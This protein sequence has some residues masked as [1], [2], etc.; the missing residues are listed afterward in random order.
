MNTQE[1]RLNFSNHKIFQQISDQL[2]LKSKLN[3]KILNGS[4]KSF[5]ISN[6]WEKINSKILIITDS[7]KE[8][9]N[10]YNDLDVFLGAENVSILI[11]PQK[12]VRF[13]V[14][15]LDKHLIWLIDGIST[16]SA[17]QN[18]IAIAT[19]DIFDVVIPNKDDINKN[20][21]KISKSE[22]V[23]FEEFKKNLAFNGFDKK[24]FVAI[25]GDM[26]V[27]GGIIDIFPIAWENP[28]RIEFWGNEVESIR[29][30]DVLSQRSIREY[31]EVE[32]IANMFQH[33]QDKNYST[34]LNY[35]NSDS[36]LIF[37]SP[38]MISINYPDYK[39]PDGFKIININKIGESDITLKTE[40]QPQFQ[41]SVK[42]V[43][44][45]LKKLIHNSFNVY[46]SA[47]GKIHLS[48]FKDLI[49]NALKISDDE[50]KNDNNLNQNEIV[51]NTADSKETF[52]KLKWIDGAVSQGFIF[53]DLQCAVFTEHELF[54]RHRLI[55]KRKLKSENT[56][57]SLKELKQLR[58]GDF[59][60]HEDK[61]IGKFDGFGTVQMGGSEQ[62]CVRLIF[63]GGDIL[64]VNLN[65]F[66]KIQKYSAQEGVAPK[67]SKLGSSEWD[68]KKART[69]KKI[70]DI[71]R[72][73][74]KLY[75]QRKMQEGFA[76]SPDSIW[77]KEF[78]A[79]FVYEDTPDQAT[80][81][82]DVKKDMESPTPMDRLV[83][84]DVGF[85]KTEIAIRA[86]FK[87]VQ[88]GKQVAVLVP[89]TILAQQHYM[90]FRDR[91]RKYPVNV[92]VI[93]RFRTKK[94]QNDITFETKNGKVDILIGTHRLLSKDVL[95][96]NLG[97]L[98]IDEEH[99]FGVS[100]KEKLRQ[101]KANIDTL[102][103]TAT[104]IPR[105]LNFSL[106]GAR[107]LSII[108]TPPRNRLPVITEVL[109]WKNERIEKAILDEISRGGQVFLVNDKVKDLEKIAVNL[110]TRIPTISFG[111]AHGQM[112]PKELE[113]VMDKFIDKK[114]DVLATT[115]IVES[116]LDIP[117]ANTII[118][119][120]AQNFGLAELYQLR[121]RVGRS[122][123][124]AYC[125]LI[126]PPFQTLSA[127]SL[128]RLQAIEEFTDL[129]S[130]FQL[131]MRDME[132]RGAGNLLGGEQSGF[133][134]E[135]GFDLF[136]KIL[137]EAVQE[138]RNDEF[139]DLFKDTKKKPNLFKNDDISIELEFDAMFPP[140]YI[141]SDTERFSYYKALYNL[142]Q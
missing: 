109:E 94:Q 127:V 17:N 78:E 117:N 129:G 59:V 140:D 81:T 107:D 142:C 23:D 33:D 39:V 98:I 36:I 41:G 106:M 102:T 58:I 40:L 116:G 60:V 95:F 74:I 35:L 53:E 79:S 50:N 63:E 88:S 122:N 29:E 108:E 75:A 64:Y 43:A 24:D 27:R 118:I 32:F 139:S 111:I 20:K 135:I 131:A 7:G 69:K 114:F 54:N 15:N 61:G 137:E 38:E 8:A 119:N 89:T 3:L 76:F 93:S 14:E 5:V 1:F 83:C 123:T 18:G 26:A 56:G 25:Q 9:E 10:L 85:G 52:K 130:G 34:I 11:E 134:N 62:E 66:H 136:Q 112:N 70:K 128:R 84:G 42:S 31:N 110:K 91:L 37:D 104:P 46:L 57:I 86:A 19:P 48:R 22:K 103:L 71:A 101:L 105:T 82:E 87:A 99:R 30:F 92:N 97:L 45:E 65:Y 51:D 72:D 120:R 4:S 90:S 13:E 47:D 49:E 21:L 115:K 141:E 68:R 96:K 124:Q 73:L 138:L 77:Q 100:A 44:L 16:F 113:D 125:Y 80:T 126:V 12:T 133:I 28:L 132:I 55:G 2:N 67:L 6:I 121:G